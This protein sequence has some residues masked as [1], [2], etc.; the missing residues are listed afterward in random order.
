MKGGRSTALA[1]VVLLGILTGCEGDGT[2]GT[3]A[4]G[5]PASASTTPF[6]VTTEPVAVEPGT[7]R[8]PSSRSSVADFTVTLPD[9]WMVQYGENFSKH[10]DTDEGVGFYGVRVDDIYA[11]ACVG[12]D[13]ELTEVGSGVD[14]LATALLQQPGPVTSGPVETTLGGYPAMRVDLKVP[15]GYSFKTCSLRD[16]LQIWLSPPADYTV[17]FPDGDASAYIID[18][19][20]ERQVFWTWAGSG[21]SDEDM[22]EFQAVLDSIDFQI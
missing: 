2:A 3:P 1:V 8:M 12:M 17:L 21:V 15:E 10:A 5:P 19:E 13:G 4:S 14:D 7:Y 9:G 18:V 20:G 22:Q 16:A 6:E 11:D